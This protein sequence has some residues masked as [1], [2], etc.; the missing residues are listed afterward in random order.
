MMGPACGE[1]MEANMGFEIRSDSYKMVRSIYND[2]KDI[3]DGIR[4]F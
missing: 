3:V 2:L 1:Q 4:H